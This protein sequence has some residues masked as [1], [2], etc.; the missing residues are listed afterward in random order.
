[1]T[2]EQHAEREFQLAR[3]RKSISSIAT[4]T[5]RSREQLELTRRLFEACFAELKAQQAEL[6]SAILALG[7]K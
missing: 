4:K 7:K 6:L 3:I 2:S 5:N 1:M